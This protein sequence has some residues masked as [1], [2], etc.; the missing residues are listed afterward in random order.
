MKHVYP[1]RHPAWLDDPANPNATSPPPEPAQPPGGKAPAAPQQREIGR[2]AYGDV[3]DGSAD[4]DRG[5]VMDEVYNDKVAPD[6]G[7]L[8]PRQ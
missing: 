3:V 6:R 2:K 1:P 4:T 7:P 5:P 8:E